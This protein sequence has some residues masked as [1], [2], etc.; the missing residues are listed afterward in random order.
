MAEVLNMQ[1]HD[2]VID[3]ESLNCVNIYGIYN[4]EYTT[5]QD[6]LD[7]FYDNYECQNTCRTSI[8]LHSEQFDNPISG[9]DPSKTM[10]QLK[11]NQISKIVLKYDSSCDDNA[12]TVDYDRLS[13]L[14]SYI[15]D[16]NNDQ[17]HTMKIY[18][19]TLLGTK[20]IQLNVTSD[21]TIYEIKLLIQNKEGMPPEQINLLFAG[22]LS[23]NLTLGD[24]NIPSGSIL[25]MIYCKKGRKHETNGRNGNYSTLQSNIFFITPNEKHDMTS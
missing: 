10:K 2:N 6:V 7:S 11:F 16:D 14:L 20:N 25:H 19:K 18:C 4:P 22:H 8:E 21:T 9:F 17:S 3:F 13:R 1:I 23:N 12:A 24:Y 15:S 5:L